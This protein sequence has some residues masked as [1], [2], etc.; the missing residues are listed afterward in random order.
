MENVGKCFFF[1]WP[2]PLLWTEKKK[3]NALTLLYLAS[4]LL[5]NAANSSDVS[6]EFAAEHNKEAKS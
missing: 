5:P 2:K 6:A 4:G 1:F 3:Q